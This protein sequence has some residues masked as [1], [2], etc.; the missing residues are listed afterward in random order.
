MQAPSIALYALL[1][2]SITNVTKRV[3]YY[4]FFPWLF[5]QYARR[6]GD[7]S[8]T[9]WLLFLRRAEALLALASCAANDQK[10]EGIVGVNWAWR[11]WEKRVAGGY[12][13]YASAAVHGAAGGY[14]AGKLGGYGQIYSNPLFELGILSTAA[15]HSIPVQSRG[16]GEKLAQSFAASIGREGEEFI[17]KLEQEDVDANFL[18][19]VGRRIKPDAIPQ[20]STER[21]LLEEV[22][23]SFDTR[24][25]EDSSARRESLGLCLSIADQMGGTPTPNHIR[26]SLY[27]GHL[28]DGAVFLTPKSLSNRCEMWQ[29]YQANELGHI[30][31]ESLLALLLGI[32]PEHGM[33]LGLLVHKVVET[34]QAGLKTSDES[35]S[36]YCRSQGIAPNASDYSDD[37]SEAAL[38]RFV[39]DAGDPVE[40]AV[41]GIRLLAALDRR[42][43]G[44]DHPVGRTFGPT[45][46]LGMRFP[47]SIRGTLAFLRSHG[48]APL[49]RTL[50]RLVQCFIV[51]QHLRVALHKL[52]Q[53]GKRTFLFELD[54]DLMIRRLLTAPVLTNPRLSSAIGFLKDLH[55]VDNNGPTMRGKALLATL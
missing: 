11:A 18:Q 23:F 25:D 13:P 10:Q 34:V 46:R 41:A 53:Q 39:L 29:A 4:S 7:T 45:N 2:P 19:R 43:A 50:A 44:Y 24:N 49:D 40:A 21:E 31:L 5:D 15:G 26:W 38:S 33:E 28:P 8:R 32:I 17:E 35:W 42:W 20:D 51:E 37:S 52:H 47:Q 27:S 36:A 22:L 1:V 6:K 55:L 3:R 30:A 48:N 14:W 9:T 54:D 16:T 12:I